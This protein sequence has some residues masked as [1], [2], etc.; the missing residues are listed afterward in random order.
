MKYC[1][2]CGKGIERRNAA[3][4]WI[5]DTCTVEKVGKGF[6]VAERSSGYDGFRCQKCATWVYWNAVRECDCDKV[7]G[8]P[9]QKPEDRTARMEKALKSIA[10]YGKK[11]PGC[12]FSCAT[13]AEK[14]L[15]EN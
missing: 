12:G 2:D 1:E 6:W 8:Q 5:C 10:E 9:V 13:M 3:G 4:M 14:A 7:D 15:E 11:N